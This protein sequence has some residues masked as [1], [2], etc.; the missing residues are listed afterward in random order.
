MKRQKQRRI[1]TVLIATVIAGAPLLFL[2]STLESSDP[3]PGGDASSATS[4]TSSLPRDAA[5]DVAP[6]AHVGTPN[7]LSAI[8]YGFGSVWVTWWDN[9]GKRTSGFLAELDPETGEELARLEVP[10]SP[11]EDGS[12]SLAVGQ[13]LLWIVGHQPGTTFSDVVLV[14]LQTDPLRVV[15]EVPL[16]DGDAGGVTGSPD[17]GAWATVVTRDKSGTESSRAYYVSPTTWLVE[18]Q[19]DLGSMR[20]QDL[21]ATSAGRLWVRGPILEN[22]GLVGEVLKG[23]DLASLTEVATL[24]D[25]ADIMWD[26]SRIWIRHADESTTY[27]QEFDETTGEVTGDPLLLPGNVQIAG[28]AGSGWVVGSKVQLVDLANMTTVSSAQVDGGEAVAAS[29]QAVWVL[30]SDS[31]VVLVRVDGASSTGSTQ[32]EPANQGVT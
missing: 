7:N 6:L 32:G 30:K 5:L 16:A 14:A 13:N 26:G 1:L 19:I 22:G 2:M 29:S 17:G 21:V 28:Q 12:G 18:Q 24:P 31:T 9:E 10:Y 23:F 4:S 25:V 20:G 27:L 8:A 11:W 15:A 3:R